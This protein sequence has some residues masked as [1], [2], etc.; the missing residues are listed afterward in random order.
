MKDAR[1]PVIVSVVT[2]LSNAILNVLLFK[3]MGLRGLPLGTT[4][5]ATINAGLLLWLL[6]KRIGGLDG[7][8]VVK[9]FLKIVVA[10]AAMGA[11]AYFTE[12]EL[13]RLLP[14]VSTL[15]K[16]VRVAGGIGA[17]VITLV[18]AAHFM[19]IEEFRQAT[20]RVLKKVRG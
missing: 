9:V 3:V 6:S 7:G 4:I 12:A 17:G 10:S 8:H 13:H 19:H 14:A 20:D 5:A 1:T 2:V 18:V 15:D 11:A 16:L